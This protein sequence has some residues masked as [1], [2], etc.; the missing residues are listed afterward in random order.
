MDDFSPLTTSDLHL[1]HLEI[2]TPN[3]VIQGDSTGPFHRASDLV[4]RKDRDYILL[5]GARITPLGRPVNSNPLTTPLM[6]ARHHT[7]LIAIGLE[8]EPEHTT[9]GLGQYRE[10]AVHKIPHPCYMLTEV[11]VLVGEVH[12]VEQSSL[13]NLMA[14][15][16]LFLPITNATIY[17]NSMPNNPLS[18]ELVMINKD[19]IQAMYLM[20]SPTTTK[21]LDETSTT[22]AVTY[23][24]PAEPAAAPAEQAAPAD[25][26]PGAA[27]SSRLEHMAS[28]E[29]GGTS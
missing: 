7:H 4:N 14:V 10:S 28:G 17:I 15:S 6:V 19:E 23:D 3:L 20:P 5:D 12:M 26:S 16:D 2:F 1:H 21:K 25:E 13:E 18:R 24:T 8:P 29:Q 9:G 27:T 22:S 11:F